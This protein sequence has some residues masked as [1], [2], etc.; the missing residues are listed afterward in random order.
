[1]DMIFS[2]VIGT[3]AKIHIASSGHRRE[4]ITYETGE[5]HGVA[6]R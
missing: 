6:R 5:S 2:R 4:T 3:F 1:M